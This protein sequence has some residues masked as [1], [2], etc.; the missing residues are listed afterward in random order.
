MMT[1]QEILDYLTNKKEELSKKY[2][3]S[4]LGLTGSYAVG[5]G[6]LGKSI[7]IFVE[8]LPDTPDLID[9]TKKLRQD[10]E[11]K[12]QTKIDIWREKY[13]NQYYKDDIF[14]EGIIV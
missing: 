8:F 6:K 9:K 7:E 5:N 13:L 14:D 11:Q 3:L 4:K 10:L 12:F 1:K 2:S